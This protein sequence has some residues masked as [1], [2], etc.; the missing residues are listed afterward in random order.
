MKPKIFLKRPTKLTK[1]NYKE[2]RENANNLARNE[3]G[4]ITTDHT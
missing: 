1:F 2:K 4:D 3:N